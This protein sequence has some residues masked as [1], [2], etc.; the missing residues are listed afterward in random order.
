M[1]SLDMTK[2]AQVTARASKIAS[3]LANEN[4]TLRQE[5]AQLREKIA[6]YERA[7]RIRSLAAQMEEQGLNAELTLEEK[8]ASLSQVEDLD[9]VEE[10][11]K[12]AGAGSLK[13]ASVSEDLHGQSFD[14]EQDLHHYLITGG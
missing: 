4:D 2:V 6:S 5:N 8:V 7:D 9:R 3:A 11:M 13:L 1:T 12:I 10:A 14:P